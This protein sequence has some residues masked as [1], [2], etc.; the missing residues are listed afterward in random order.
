[1]NLWTT[2]YKPCIR[3]TP[4]LQKIATENNTVKFVLLSPDEDPKKLERF[5]TKYPIIDIMFKN[6][7]YKVI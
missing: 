1:M 2:C 7:G 5:I 4:D 6:K 3:E